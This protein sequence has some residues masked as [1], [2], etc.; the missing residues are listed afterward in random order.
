MGWMR[1]P[2]LSVLLNQPDKVAQG[3][4]NGLLNFLENIVPGHQFC[5]NEGERCDFSGAADIAYG[6]GASFNYISGISG[7]VD[8]NNAVFGDPASGAPKACYIKGGGPLGYVY[9]IAEGGRCDFSGVAD[10]AYGAS[11]RYNYQFRVTG[12]IDCNNTVFGDPIYGTAKACYYKSL[13]PPAAPTDL[14]ASDG[15]YPDQVSLTWS[16]PANVLYYQ[17]YR[18]VSASS[19]Q[20][21]L[22]S[23]TAPGYADTN[24][25]P[26][27]TYYY[28]VKACNANG[29]SPFSSYD[30]GYALITT[31][32]IYLPMVVR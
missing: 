6:T 11:L 22:S 2:D 12:G 4:A 10:V 31:L 27:V 30:A 28:W 15:D 5:V 13:P 18:A 8:C 16:A 19:T 9:C 26:G 20:N 17:V 7:G 21:L 25:E 24:A 1:D 3:I 23:P 14:Q 29:C 32:K